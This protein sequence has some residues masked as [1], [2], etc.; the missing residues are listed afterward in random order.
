[1]Q[2]YSFEFRPAGSNAG[3]TL[4][5]I[6]NHLSCKPHTDLSLNKANQIESTFTQIINSRKSSIIAGCLYIHPNMDVS[7]FN[8]N[9]LKTL[10]Y[11]L[12]K[13]N[14]Q[15][16]LLG[17]FNL[18]NYN[19]H[20]PTNKFLVSLTSNSFIPYILQPIR[21]NSHSKL[22]NI[23][24]HEVIS[25]NITSTISDHLP[26]FLFTHN[27][28][29]NNSCQKSNTCERDYYNQYLK[30]TM[31]NIK[32]TWKEKKSIISIKNLSSDI[33][34]SSSY[35]GLTTTNKVEISN[36]FNN[37]FATIDINPS[38]KHFSDF[39]KNR[40]QNSFFL[41]PTNKPE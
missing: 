9:Y 30:A 36:I 40:T 7:G 37:Y 13:E 25:G 11:K 1:M 15:V 33:R 21:I 4:L 12:S 2:N 18:L 22:S 24:P 8:K 35:N 31:N 26:P 41:S 6:A 28:L 27:V 16:F 10:F 29:S 23:I 34:K 17:D 39:L 38:N 3:G 32:N 5:Y 19:D 14:M 20:Q